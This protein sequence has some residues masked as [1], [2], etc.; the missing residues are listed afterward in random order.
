MT[1]SI[2][3]YTP[4]EASKDATFDIQSCNKKPNIP[5]Q[6]IQ[7]Q[8][9]HTELNPERGRKK[10]ETCKIPLLTKRMIYFKSSRLR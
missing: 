5:T 9:L 3:L 10:K 2:D 8:H 1:L 4:G 7:P 6:Y